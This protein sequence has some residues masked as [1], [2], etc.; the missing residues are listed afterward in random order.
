MNKS[1]VLFHS[2]FI[3]LGLVIYGKSFSEPLNLS[4]LKNELIQYHDSGEYMKDVKT[5]FQQAQS[6]ITQQAKQ[7]KSRKIALILD[8]DETCLSN[9]D[10]L[11]ARDFMNDYQRIHRDTLKADATPILP[12]LRLFNTAKKQHIHV[13]FISGRYEFERKV[14]IKNLHHAGFNGWDGLLLQSNNQYG[15]KGT[16]ENFKIAARKEI[17][18]KGYT[19]IANIGDQPTDLSGGYARKTF[20]VPNPFYYSPSHFTANNKAA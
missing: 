7:S 2:L 10:D 9:Y 15:K 3:F 20:K 17:T 6:Y 1:S 12:S 13:F 4:I 18:K 11:I 14:T 5:I 8:I 19:I 16:I